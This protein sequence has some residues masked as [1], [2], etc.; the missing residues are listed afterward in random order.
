PYTTLFRSVQ[1]LRH[2]RQAGLLANLVQDLQAFLAQTLERIGRGARLE[3]APPVQRRAR[4]PHGPAD[5]HG[6]GLRLDGARP[7][8]DDDL[9]AADGDTAD[10]DDG[11]LAL[12][13]PG[14]EL[15]GGG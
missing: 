5:L 8:D 14:D 13:L 3:G 1:D 11:V 6:L 9:R 2:D 10:R 12:G 4:V 15:V 7:R